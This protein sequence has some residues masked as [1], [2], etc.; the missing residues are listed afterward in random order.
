MKTKHIF[1]YIH[2][3]SLLT[4]VTSGYLDQTDKVGQNSLEDSV[5]STFD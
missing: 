3:L 2:C 1:I 5:L 4:T